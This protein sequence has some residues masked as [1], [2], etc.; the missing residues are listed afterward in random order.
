MIFTIAAVILVGFITVAVIG[1]RE[2]QLGV[3]RLDTE[4]NQFSYREDDEMKSSHPARWSSSAGGVD[5]LEANRFTSSL[6]ALSKAQ[7]PLT[8]DSPKHAHDELS[9]LVSLHQP[10]SKS[11]SQEP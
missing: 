6:L 11:L 4:S 2:A 1:V 5:A 7:T 3:G 10:R 8:H 9:S